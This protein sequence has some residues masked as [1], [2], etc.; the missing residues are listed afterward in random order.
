MS[1]LG[2]WA[3]G[4]LL[5]LP[6]TSPALELQAAV[7]GICVDTGDQ[8]RGLLTEPSSSLVLNLSTDKLF[9]KRVQCIFSPVFSF[10]GTGFE[11]QGCLLFA[12]TFV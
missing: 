12:F 8:S 3:S 11:S 2:Q 4:I 10:F 6:S 9:S 1:L 5:S 7:P